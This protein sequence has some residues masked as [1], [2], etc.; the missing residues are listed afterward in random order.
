MSDIVFQKTYDGESI[1]DVSEDIAYA[2]QVSTVPQ[3]EYGFQLGEFKVTV[4][5]V[6]PTEVEVK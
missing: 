5:W 4:E 1:I 6:S 2:I 3:D